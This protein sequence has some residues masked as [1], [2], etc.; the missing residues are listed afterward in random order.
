MKGKAKTQFTDAD[1]SA[2]FVSDYGSSETLVDY[3]RVDPTMPYSDASVPN[4]AAR[5]D[6]EVT[7]PEDEG[8]T[9]TD[10]GYEVQAPSGKT[11]VTRP[12]VGWLVCIHGVCFG[13]D[14]RLHANYNR[15][16]RS[17]ALDVN[18]DDPK[19]SKK[20]VAWVGYFQ[21]TNTFYVGADSSTN[22][23]Y[24][25]DLPLPSGQSQK[26]AAWDRI[27]MGDTE[28]IF[29]PLCGETFTWNKANEGEQ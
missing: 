16:G 26:L 25:N 11:R 18:I 4:R 22:V 1:V 29:V 20:A 24:V 21:E 23:L 3:S 19:F 15:I 6:E 9:Q 2:G 5:F 10:D 7:E 13:V 8:V 27:R 12:T 17:A 28:L 14:Y